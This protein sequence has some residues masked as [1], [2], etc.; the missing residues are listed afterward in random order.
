MKISMRI[1]GLLASLTCSIQLFA[2]PPFL[3][4]LLAPPPPNGLNQP[5]SQ[6]PAVASPCMGNQNNI[7]DSRVPP[8]GTY[9]IQHTDGS[10]EHIY[11]TGEKKPYYVGDPCGSSNSTQAMVYPQ[12][13]TPYVTTPYDTT[14]YATAPGGIGPGGVVGPVGPSPVGP[15]GMGPGP[16]RAGPIGGFRGGRFHR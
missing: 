16:G 5:V 15:G 9:T 6:S 1:L 14:T 7:Y 8:E 3:N 4:N 13:T 2:L 12:V 10:S 11:T